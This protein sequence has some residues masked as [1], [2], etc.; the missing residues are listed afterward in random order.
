M[1]SSE[2]T[3]KGASRD[4]ATDQP[5]RPSPGIFFIGGSFHPGTNSR[6]YQLFFPNLDHALRPDALYGLQHVFAQPD[7][8]LSSFW[9]GRAPLLRDVSR[10]V[11]RWM[12]SRIH[13]SPTS[14]IKLVFGIRRTRPSFL[15]KGQLTRPASR[16][17]RPTRIMSHGHSSIVRGSET[18]SFYACLPTSNG[19]L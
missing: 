12:Y 17:F 6:S 13:I 3:A 8:L 5:V 19:W 10:P 7:V 1:S 2:M 18:V 16:W 9:K 15:P 4:T 11:V 14:A